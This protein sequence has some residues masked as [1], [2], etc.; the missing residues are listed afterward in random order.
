MIDVL[1]ANKK[2]IVFLG[3]VLLIVLGFFV[4]RKRP[5]PIDPG[6][7]VSPTPSTISISESPISRLSPSVTRMPTFPLISGALDGP[8]EGVE[9]YDIDP[10]TEKQYIQV[11]KLLTVVPYEGTHFSLIYDIGKNDYIATINASNREA[12]EQE[13]DAFL[14]NNGIESRSWIHN[15]VIEYK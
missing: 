15:L 3:I 9:Y 10:E 11:G 14:K 5:Q 12:G 6:T 7:V 1:Q 2:A 8:Q 13:M 4:F